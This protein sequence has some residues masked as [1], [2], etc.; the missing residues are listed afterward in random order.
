MAWSFRRRPAAGLERL[1]R[2]GSRREVALALA[3]HVDQ[4]LARSEAAAVL[5]PQVM[6][7]FDHA[8]G[9]EIVDHA[10]GAAAKGRKADTEKGADVAVPRVA[11]YT[12]GECH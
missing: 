9:S 11:D 12:V 6:K 10:E 4:A 8:G 1:T 3:R 7:H 5:I 2:N